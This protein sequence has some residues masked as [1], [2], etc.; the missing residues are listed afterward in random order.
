MADALDAAKLLYVEVKHV[1]RPCPLVPPDEL[2]RLEGPKTREAM[3]AKHSGDART[4]QLQ[5]RSN[6][7]DGFSSPT[8]LKDEL[9][10]SWLEASGASVRP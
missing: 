8:E 6:L 4:A 10:P 7:Q 1:P 9:L 5:G 2:H 3:A